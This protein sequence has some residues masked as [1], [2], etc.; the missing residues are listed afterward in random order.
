M[1]QWPGH[2]YVNTNGLPSPHLLGNDFLWA[3]VALL[4]VGGGAQ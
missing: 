4:G 3:A 2:G 1:H